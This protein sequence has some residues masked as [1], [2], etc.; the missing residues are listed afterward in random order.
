MFS[1]NK[2]LNIS[3]D[4]QNTQC[5]RNNGCRTICPKKYPSD[6]NETQEGSWIRREERNEMYKEQV[7]TTACTYSQKWPLM[8]DNSLIAKVF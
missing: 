3:T 6:P 1:R 8:S 2:N 4:Q 7:V 5:S